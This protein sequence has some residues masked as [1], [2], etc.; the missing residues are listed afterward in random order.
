MS[1]TTNAKLIRITNQLGAPI[2]G[3]TKIIFVSIDDKE[4]I[5][6]TD[7]ELYEFPVSPLTTDISA[8]AARY[9]Y[10][11][12]LLQDDGSYK[13]LS[14]LTDPSRNEVLEDKSDDELFVYPDIYTGQI[15]SLEVEEE[16]SGY[17]RI[18]YDFGTPVKRVQLFVED[19]ETGELFQENEFRELVL[20]DYDEIMSIYDSLQ[21]FIIDDTN[22]KMYYQFNNQEGLYEIATKKVASIPNA[23]SKTGMKAGAYINLDTSFFGSDQELLKERQRYVN[24]RRIYKEIDDK[25]ELARDLLEEVESEDES[26]DNEI[27]N[28]NSDEFIDPNDSAQKIKFNLDGSTSIESD[29][30]GSTNIEIGDVLKIK[31]NNYFSFVTIKSLEIYENINEK[32][33]G[34]QALIS[35]YEDNEIFYLNILNSM[36][37]YVSLP[38]HRDPA[39]PFPPS[40]EEALYGLKQDLINNTS[41][42]KDILFVKKLSGSAKVEETSF[43]ELDDIELIRVD[44]RIEA[45]YSTIQD[46]E[47]INSTEINFSGTMQPTFSATR[48]KISSALKIIKSKIREKDNSFF[49]LVRDEKFRMIDQIPKDELNKRLKLEIDW[50]EPALID[51]EQI[52]EYN[53]KYFTVKKDKETDVINLITNYDRNKFGFINNTDELIS[54][55][56][57]SLGSAIKSSNQITKKVRYKDLSPQS[58]KIVEGNKGSNIITVERGIFSESD[59]A[60]SSTQ[61]A[62][63]KLLQL[64]QNIYHV[65]RFI[66]PTEIELD[67][68]L[69]L[70]VKNIDLIKRNKIPVFTATKTD[71]SKIDIDV[72]YDDIVLFMV[73]AI[74]EEGIASKWVVNYFNVKTS[75]YKDSDQSLDSF[76]ND[77]LNLTIVDDI[78]EEK[79]LTPILNTDNFKWFNLTR[80]ESD[81]KLRETIAKFLEERKKYELAKK[82]SLEKQTELAFGGLSVEAFDLKYNEYQKVMF[83]DPTRD[84]GKY[85][86]GGD[87]KDSYFSILQTVNLNET[88]LLET[89]LQLGNDYFIGLTFNPPTDNGVNIIQYV[90]NYKVKERDGTSK[91]GSFTIPDPNSDSIYIR[92]DEKELY[93]KTKKKIY[94]DP[95]TGKGFYEEEEGIRTFTITAKPGIEYEFKVAAIS[96][97]NVRSE[98]S[99]KVTYKIEEETDSTLDFLNYLQDFNTEVAVDKKLIL[100]MR[101]MDYVKKSLGK[102]AISTG[103]GSEIKYVGV[104]EAVALMEARL[105]AL[106]GA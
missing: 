41:I 15:V 94:K 63:E 3:L 29:D 37:F 8:Y 96:E 73:Q 55:V 92:L 46:V 9:H 62:E 33:N 95:L 85:T 32:I 56:R 5:E 66:S 98:W 71:E 10:P 31:D 105:K 75:N 27:W 22:K 80:K 25:L 6:D 19:K 78:T 93:S 65:S 13:T 60:T 57:T 53:V 104:T 86:S 24:E 88:K 72:D 14:T 61:K 44:N 68:E 51:N 64:G 12:Y 67:R 16:G 102:V 11:I 4:R 103:V 59:V 23:V 20:V 97:D 18:V 52:T 70:D 82:L 76:I 90:L 77:V 91:G 26:N 106:E 2:T 36:N 39:T 79:P 17:Y 43:T 38:E 87:L 74:T 84:D 50:N 89:Q 21:K 34:D 42:Y 47:G 101:E 99:N 40:K 100:H 7:R 30:L 1:D 81:S 69:D 35:S 45:I 48:R 83:G 28:M 54:V 49:S 58:S